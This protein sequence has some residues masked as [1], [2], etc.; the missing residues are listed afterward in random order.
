MIPNNFEY[1]RATS[2]QEAIN[3]LAQGGQGARLLAGGHS[4]IPAMKLRLNSPQTLIDISGIKELHEIKKNGDQLAIGALAT[5]HSVA[6]SDLVKQNCPALAE[7]AALIGD[8][9]VRNHGTI[10]GSLAHCDP[11]ADYP[12]M[13]LALDARIEVAGSAGSSTI[14]ADDFFVGMFETALKPGEVI[15]RI[16]VPVTSKGSGAAYEKFPHPAARFAIVGVAANVSVD[17]QGNCTSARIGVTGAASFAFRAKKAEQ[18]L[19]GK[20]LN[21]QTIHDATRDI[22]DPADLMG[23]MF[24]SAEYRAHLCSVLAEKALTRAAERAQ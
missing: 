18:A 6:T 24:A 4:L 11:A 16:T 15:T 22:A 12:A 1:V 23:D 8:P 10:G 7:G 21:A 19:V 3:Q 9:Q 20:P 2:I 13:V 5:H 17:G 14:A